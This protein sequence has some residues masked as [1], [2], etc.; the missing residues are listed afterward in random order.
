M[1]MTTFLVNIRAFVAI[2]GPF[3]N[4]CALKNAKSYHLLENFRDLDD[5]GDIG[6]LED[7]KVSKVSKVLK[8]LK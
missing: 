5:L 7:L 3:S 6:D 1:P 8:V 2:F 4:V